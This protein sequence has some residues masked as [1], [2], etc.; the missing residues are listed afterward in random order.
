M[1]RLIIIIVVAIMLACIGYVLT[2]VYHVD[3]AGKAL[4]IVQKSPT[5]AYIV[6]NII[7]RTFV[8]IFILFAILSLAFIPTP[9]EVTYLTLL[10]LAQDRILVFVAASCGVLVGQIVNYGLGRLFSGLF[11]QNE[12]MKASIE[13]SGAWVLFT[14]NILPFVPS[15]LFNLVAGTVKFPFVKWLI[16]TIFGVLIYFGAITL[17]A[18]QLLNFF[19]H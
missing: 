9:L 10:T 11:K 16:V 19:F 1:K 6:G 3:I 4:A 5:G 2:T 18:N 8:G 17:A 15:Q 7:E 14:A 12:K 13:K